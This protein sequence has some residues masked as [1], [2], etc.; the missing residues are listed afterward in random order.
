MRLNLMSK[1]FQNRIHL[2]KVI[3]EQLKGADMRWTN[4]LKATLQECGTPR[5][6]EGIIKWLKK[7]KYIDSPERGLYKITE[8]GKKFLS[9]L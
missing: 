2:A 6:F 4:L 1:R 9:T 5:T 7:Q 8:Q 3:L